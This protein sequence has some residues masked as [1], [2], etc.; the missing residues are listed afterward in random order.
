MQRLVSLRSIYH[1]CER[2]MCDTLEAINDVIG[3]SIPIAKAMGIRV[4]SL[5]DSRITLEAPFDPNRNDKGTAFAG[6][7]YSI[8]AL[9]GWSLVTAA[10]MK[11]SL[12][13]E[14]MITESSIRFIKPVTGALKAIAAFRKSPNWKEIQSRLASGRAAKVEVVCSFVDADGKEL[15]SMEAKYA[16]CLA[17]NLRTGRTGRTCL[18][19]RTGLRKRLPN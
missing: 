5:D 3:A 2:Q 19:R 4:I 9:A 11:R 15:A 12:A 14:V 18:T 17:N 16:I 10:G 13:T 1:A 8:M 7:I 6:S